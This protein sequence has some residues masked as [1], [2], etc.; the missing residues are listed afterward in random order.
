MGTPDF[1]DAG[2]GRVVDYG[3][4]DREAA[5]A[6]RRT[7]DE[8]VIIARAAGVK[9]D[10]VA[11][12]AAGPVWKA[13]VDVADR[14]AA[15]AIVMGSRGLSGM[16]SILLGSVSSAVVHHADRPTLVIRHSTAD[17]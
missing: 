5:R 7:A 3:A 9:A 17:A 10:A 2:A 8:C 13:I 6:G 15:A 14:N 4:L 1:P 16:R 12:R 11:I